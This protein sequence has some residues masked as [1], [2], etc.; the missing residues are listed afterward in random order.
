MNNYNFTSFMSRPGQALR[1][2]GGW[3]SHN[4]QSV[5]TWRWQCS[6]T[7]LPHL[8]AGNIPGTHFCWG[9]GVVSRIKLMKNPS[10]PHQ[11]LNTRPGFSTVPQ[12]T[13]PCT[14]P[15]LCGYQRLICHLSGRM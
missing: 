14:P 9:H 13:M 8:P 11:E 12:P 15:V 10:D 7:H 3:S 6:H 1:A 4:F 2:S 5:G